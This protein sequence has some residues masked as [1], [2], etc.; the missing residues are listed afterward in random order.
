[1][2]NEIDHAEWESSGIKIV[3]KDDQGDNFYVED[4]IRGGIMWPS[5]LSPGYIVIIGRLPEYND[6]KI[7]P[8]TV[9]AEH[10]CSLPWEMIK[11]IT[12][13][14]RRLFCK[15]YYADLTKE[16]IIYYEMLEVHAKQFAFGK[17]SVD[18]PYLGDWL[19]GILSIEQWMANEALQL[20]KGSILRQQM[21]SL[22]FED[23]DSSRRGPYYAMD[24]LRC[25]IGSYELPARKMAK[26][27]KIKQYY[28]G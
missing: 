4:A 26:T 18:V 19:N 24:A 7:K 16:N 22:K 14:S 25:V 11:I 9:L 17:I 3:H 5:T 21:A 28:Y 15:D 1:M 8:L 20:P 12:N 13:E 27:K 6:N 23:R 2:M 10:L